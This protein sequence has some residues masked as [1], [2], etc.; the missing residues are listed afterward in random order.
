MFGLACVARHRIIHILS[1]F[2]QVPLLRAGFPC[3][4]GW[5]YARG[6]SATAMRGRPCS[7][8][9]IFFWGSTMTFLPTDPSTAEPRDAVPASK[10]PQAGAGVVCHH[11]RP[12]SKLP[13]LLPIVPRSISISA[14]RSGLPSMRINGERTKL[15]E[16]AEFPKRAWMAT[17]LAQKIAALAGCAA[18]YCL[19]VGGSAIR[20]LLAAGIQPIRL[21]GWHRRIA[22]TTALCGPR[23]RRCLDRSCCPSG[24]MDDVDRFDR[25]AKKVRR[26][27]ERGGTAWH[28]HQYPGRRCTRSPVPGGCAAAP[29]TV[30]PAPR[31]S[32]RSSTCFCRRQRLP[33]PRLSRPCRNPR[34][35]CCAARVSVA[36]RRPSG[37]RCRRGALFP[38]IS[39]RSRV[40]SS[41]S[42]WG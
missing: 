40:P 24:C 28:C 29:G 38:A 26:N 39:L 14:H 37:R 35:C 20:Q 8:S 19:A 34:S 31:P 41:G 27:D 2:L 21:D 42:F 11:R 16:V 22:G 33:D 9:P 15:V 10:R 32:P 36:G 17:K 6:L 18:V 13:S 30:A 1:W 12:C 5:G 3:T 23:R 7:I 4:T 25:M